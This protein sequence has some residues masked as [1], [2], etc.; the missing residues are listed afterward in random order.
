MISVLCMLKKHLSSTHTHTH[1]YCEVIL[2]TWCI[3]LTDLY[4]PTGQKLGEGATGS[5]ATY[6]RRANG[7]EYAVKV[8]LITFLG[9]KCAQWQNY[10]ATLTHTECNVFN[11]Q[12]LCSPQ[13][14]SKYLLVISEM[15]Q[16]CPNVVV[17]QYY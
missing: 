3:L 5:V 17:S 15:L 8:Y 6:R 16:C 1:T 2:F 7:E 4:E 9:F 10:I 13:T 11:R 12:I 14:N